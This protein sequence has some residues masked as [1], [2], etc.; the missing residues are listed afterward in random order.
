M[1]SIYKCIYTLLYQPNNHETDLL[2]LLLPV[3][4]FGQAK[5]DGTVAETRTIAFRY[6][7]NKKNLASVGKYQ[8]PNVTYTNRLR[9]RPKWAKAPLLKSKSVVWKTGGSNLCDTSVRLHY[10][11]HRWYQTAL[12]LARKRYGITKA[13]HPDGIF[14][15]RGKMALLNTAGWKAQWMGPG[16]AEENEQPSPMFGK[17][18]AVNKKEYYR[19]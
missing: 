3:L 18:F 12:L 2:L 6:R 15:P 5:V 9:Q 19:R 8:F 13:R 16:Y 4:G 10:E 11:A 7:R 17:Q 1:P 14:L